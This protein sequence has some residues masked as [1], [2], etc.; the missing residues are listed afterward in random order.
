MKVVKVQG[1]KENSS[2]AANGCVKGR[3]N[4]FFSNSFSSEIKRTFED[5]QLRTIYEYNGTLQEPGS[6]P[7]QK[8]VYWNQRDC[9]LF[10]MFPCF[11]CL[12]S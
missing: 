7:L 4:H 2:L 9:V 3:H 12:D 1:E 11:P 5:K 8:A 6:L 10:S